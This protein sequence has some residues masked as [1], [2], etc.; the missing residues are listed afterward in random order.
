MRLDFI[1]YPTA[2]A[3]QDE[4][5]HEMEDHRHELCSAVRSKGALL[6]DCGAI[7]IRWKEHGG[8]NPERYLPNEED[9][10]GDV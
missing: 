2:W 6:C 4:V 10:T 5:G 7:G 1:D 3:L 9:E 8:E